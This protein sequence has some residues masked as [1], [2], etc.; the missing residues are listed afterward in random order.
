MSTQRRCK[1]RQEE[2]PRVEA[3]IRKMH[4]GS[5]AGSPVAMAEGRPRAATGAVTNNGEEG[6]EEEEDDV[7]AAKL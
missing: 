1:G 5:A 7:R 3:G 2:F 4:R 6:G